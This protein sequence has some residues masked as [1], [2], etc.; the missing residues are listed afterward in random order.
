MI[1]GV[2]I[3]EEACNCERGM[4]RQMKIIIILLQQMMVTH[5]NSE[6]VRKERYK[7]DKGEENK[8]V[9]SRQYYEL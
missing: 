3:V 5:P 6:F 8:N 4:K 9:R 7:E 1:I 2:L